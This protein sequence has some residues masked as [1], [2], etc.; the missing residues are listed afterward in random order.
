MSAAVSG[1]CRI[2]GINDRVGSLPV[3]EC[4]YLDEN[5]RVSHAWS[6]LPGWLIVVPRRHLEAFDE[7]SGQ[8]SAGLG[9]LLSAATAALREALGCVKTYVMMFAETP[10]FSH[11]HIHVVPR[12]ANFT[13]D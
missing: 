9:P 1:D 8:E 13:E 4:V 10:T 3:R 7:L 2:C 5:W 6:S 11:L 12:M